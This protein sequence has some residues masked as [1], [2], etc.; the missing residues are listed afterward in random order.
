MTEETVVTAPEVLDGAAVVVGSG[1]E[2]PSD[3]CWIVE[4]TESS[5]PTGF[6]VE[7]GSSV[8]TVA[9]VVDDP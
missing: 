2:D 8:V 1:V 4:G 9:S 5:E 7:E 3:S 6:V